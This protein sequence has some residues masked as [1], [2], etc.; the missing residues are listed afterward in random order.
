MLKEALIPL[1]YHGVVCCSDYSLWIIR[2]LGEGR[3][4]LALKLSLGQI[5][6]P[7]VG[8]GSRAIPFL[9]LGSYFVFN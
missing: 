3:R 4:Y 1:K 5:L 8:R 9:L 2:F 7:S 6:H